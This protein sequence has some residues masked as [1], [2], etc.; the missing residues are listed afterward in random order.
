MNFEDLAWL[1]RCDNRNRG[2]I[3]QNFDEAAL[4]W[5]SV[6]SS[7][8]PILEIGRRHGGT[9]VLLIS[10]AQGRTV[11]SIGNAPAH[12][13]SSDEFFKKVM[14]EN[15]GALRLIVGDSRESLPAENRFGLIFIDGD[16]SYEGVRADV[17][18]HWSALVSHEGCPG[19]AVFHDAVPNEGLAHEGRLNHCIGVKQLCDELIAAGCARTVGY[20]GSSL[21]LEKI[22][23][24]PAQWVSKSFSS[25]LLKKRDDIVK[26]VRQGGVGIELGVA[27]A[28]MSERLLRHGVLSHLYCVDMYAGDR[29]HNDDQ[30]KRAIKKLSPFRSQHTLI[31]LRFDQALS[32]F[33]DE[34][35]DFIYVDGYAHTG[36]ESGATFRDWYPK[37]KPGGV[38]AGDDYHEDWPLVI[39]EVDRFLAQENLKLNLI[40]CQEDLQYCRYPTWYTFKPE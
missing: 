33:P 35:F 5:K 19:L 3:R 8:G 14:D 40:D 37:L 38:L 23:E 16:H 11:F 4:L 6:K 30:Y 10:A 18:A 17:I 27:E 7:R 21:L 13:A 28:V 20:A 36:E 1:F 24:L 15:P 34:Y 22:A 12:H 26:L 9:T 32:L 31:K 2:I 29:G 39:Q 25:P